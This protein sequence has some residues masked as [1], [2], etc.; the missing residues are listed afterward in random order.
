MW[1]KMINYIPATYSLY[2][3]RIPGSDPG[4]E[5][6]Q[7]SIKEIAEQMSKKIITNYNKL[8]KGINLVGYCG[9]SVLAVEVTYIL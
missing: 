3:V 6:I 2:G 1:V 4:E 9:G 7:Y 8:G 5:M